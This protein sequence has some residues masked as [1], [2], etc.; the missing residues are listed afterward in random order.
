K[1][2]NLF[3]NMNSNPVLFPDSRANGIFQDHAKTPQLIVR[4]SL[5]DIKSQS[6][7]LML[8]E[9]VDADKYGDIVLTGG[10]PATINSTANNGNNNEHQ[11]D[12]A[13]EF[14]GSAN[15]AERW[16]GFVWWDTSTTTPPPTSPALYAF[17]PALLQRQDATTGWPPIEPPWAAINVQK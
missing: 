11:K 7:T 4:V 15:C 10:P 16:I 6:T 3:P 14:R 2:D 5:T 17:P 1:L 9:N 12:W 13:W 8:S